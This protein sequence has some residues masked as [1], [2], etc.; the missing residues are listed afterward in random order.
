MSVLRPLLLSALCLLPFALLGCGYHVAAN[1]TSNALPLTV[2][3][4][5]I[6]A[7]SNVT[8]R[9]KLTEFL[10]GGHYTRIHLAHSLSGGERS[11]RC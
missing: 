4:I 8:V 9:Y 6:P 10:A 5:A 11:E 7:F 3:T 2:K 1:G